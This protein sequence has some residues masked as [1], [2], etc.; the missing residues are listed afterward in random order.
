[1][2]SLI[3]ASAFRPENEA[4]VSSS[5]T[6]K[7]CREF[8]GQYASSKVRL[9]TY[10]ASL[11]RLVFRV[12]SP[13]K[14]ELRPIDLVF[15]GLTQV[16]CPVHW[17]VGKLEISDDPDPLAQ[18]TAFTFSLA[19]VSIIASDLVIVVQDGYPRMW[20]LEGAI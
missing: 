11:S 6:A 18:K 19:D 4:Q 20:E 16:R 17:I 13:A 9:W 7:A 12:T 14:Q 15:V 1:M 10:S 2:I 5:L 8:L 3:N